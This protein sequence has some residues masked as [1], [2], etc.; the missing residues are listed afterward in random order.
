[1]KPYRL[2]GDAI[3]L[4]VRVTARAGRSGTAGVIDTGDGRCALAIRLAAPPVDGAANRALIEFLA[5]ALRIPRSAIRIVS[6]E[7]SRLKQVRITGTTPES[8]EQWLHRR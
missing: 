3:L 1:M 2:D 5:D 4:A 8:V 6:G 7:T